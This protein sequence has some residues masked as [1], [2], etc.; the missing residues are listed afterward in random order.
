MITE[1]DLFK[2]AK[3]SYRTEVVT[4]FDGFNREQKENILRIFELTHRI[5]N[6]DAKSLREKLWDVIYSLTN[7]GNEIEEVLDSMTH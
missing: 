7:A 1:I 3:G 4:L 2:A 6:P 5:D